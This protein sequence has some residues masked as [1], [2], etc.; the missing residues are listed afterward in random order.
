MELC[1]LFGSSRNGTFSLLAGFYTRVAVSPD[2]ARVVFEL[3]DEFS[4]IDS[5]RLTD[6]EKGLYMV[7]ADG[8][9]RVKLGPATAVSPYRR[10]A[11]GLFDFGNAIAFSPNGRHVVYTDLGPASDGTIDAQLWSLRLADGKRSQLTHLARHLGAAEPLLYVFDFTDNS[12]VG[13]YTF[14]Y[15]SGS[16]PVRQ[17]FYSVSLDGTE[18]RTLSPVIGPNGQVISAFALAGHRPAA[19]GLF[20]EGTP[21]NPMGGIDRPR[22]LFVAFGKR[23]LQLT[24]FN[25]VDVGNLPT[26]VSRNGERVFFSASADP[27][28]CN[29]TNNCQVFSVATLGGHLRQLTRFADGERSRDGC[30]FSPLPGCPVEVAAQDR[31]TGTLILNSS[32]DPFGTN[33]AANQLFAMRP[34]GS[35]L[36]Q[37]TR[38]RGVVT[39]TPEVVEVELP[40]PFAYQ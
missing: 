1:R 18:L 22:E 3:N 2:G 35:G 39:D 30:F 13:F 23:I 15:G 27:F 24:H 38:A 17:E 34:D 21:E 11:N 32:C 8:G 25:R 29:P 36:G 37:I 7:A 6:D 14:D 33:P 10:L 20:L 4:V 26:V 31:A 5:G 40:G 16:I 28:H 9:D 12:T 19:Q